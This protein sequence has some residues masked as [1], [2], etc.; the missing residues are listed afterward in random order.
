MATL[1]QLHEA[2]P[3]SLDGFRVKLTC[4]VM[5]CEALLIEYKG[6]TELSLPSTHQNTCHEVPAALKPRISPD[7]VAD[8]ALRV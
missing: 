2:D 7:R 5:Q 1:N 4:T 8:C 3:W 6:H